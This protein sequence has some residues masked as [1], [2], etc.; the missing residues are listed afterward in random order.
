MFAEFVAIVKI[1]LA[2]SFLLIHSLISRISQIH[3]PH[4]IHLYFHLLHNSAPHRIP[5]QVYSLSYSNILLTYH[6]CHNCLIC[7]YLYST[8]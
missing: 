7:C 6:D 5:I 2:Q 8:Y 1:G 3:A 4:L